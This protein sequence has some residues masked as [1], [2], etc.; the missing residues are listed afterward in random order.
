MPIGAKNT[1]QWQAEAIYPLGKYLAA[2]SESFDAYGDE[3]IPRNALGGY[4]DGY[5][6]GREQIIQILLGEGWE[7]T[8]SHFYTQNFRRKIKP[9]K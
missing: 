4:P 9:S 2:W 8:D 3:G 7:P 5:L 6:A 1:W